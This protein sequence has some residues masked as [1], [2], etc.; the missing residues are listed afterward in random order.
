MLKNL[1]HLYVMRNITT[2][3]ANFMIASSS[4]FTMAIMAIIGLM[5]MYRDNYII[6]IWSI[7]MI[8]FVLFSMWSLY[9]YI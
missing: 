9:Y 5:T 2:L 3:L 7:W 1:L 8:I 4:N 6:L